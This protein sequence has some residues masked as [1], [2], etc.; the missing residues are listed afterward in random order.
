VWF[1]CL[2]GCGRLGPR[3]PVIMNFAYYGNVLYLLINV[4]LCGLLCVV[5]F[6]FYRSVWY[7][8]L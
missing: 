5:G 4:L 7:L 1:L 6:L 3:L 8:G 2:L